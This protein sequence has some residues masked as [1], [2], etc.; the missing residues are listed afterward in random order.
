MRL[1]VVG[2][3]NA[4]SRVVNRVLEVEKRS[5]RNLCDGNVLLINTREP[6]FDTK[7]YVAEK[8]KLMIGD[9]H[10]EINGQGVDRDPDLG[11]EVAREDVNE[12]RRMFDVIE[13][14]KVDGILLVAGLGGGTGSGAGAVVIEEL[15]KICD[16]PIYAVGVLPAVAEGPEAA[17]NASRALQSFV[18]LAD[19]VI[20]FDND[21]WSSGDGKL[22]EDYAERNEELATRLVTLFAAGEMDQ[23]MAAE[24]RMDPSDIIRTLETGGISSIG[25]ASTPVEG[26]RRGFIEWLRDLPWPWRGD[27]EEEPAT[28]AA[29]INR[30]VR[31]A[32][33]SQLTLPCEISSTERALIMLSG[34][35]REL[36]RKGFESGRYW[37]EKEAD[38]VEVKAGDEPHVRAKELTAV[39]LYS[40]VTDVPRIAQMQEQALE[41]RPEDGDAEAAPVIEEEASD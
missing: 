29:K 15:Q 12:I 24:N 25:Y 30:L 2:V 1:A 5:G 20:L 21:V 18:E 4:G 28:A 35:P 38:T 9:I 13:L 11:A 10:R 26:A 19:N 27:R 14:F 37:L 31:R 36:S 22:D 40:N 41:A 34:P 23:A 6:E 32:A 8:R 16:E 7:D 39:V 17:L 3:G 33:R